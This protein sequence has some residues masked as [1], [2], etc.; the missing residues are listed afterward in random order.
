MFHL[1]VR[2]TLGY[3]VP[4]VLTEHLQECPYRHNAS[5]RIIYA[6]VKWFYGI[7]EYNVFLFCF[8]LQV[9]FQ[10]AQEVFA[11]YFTP[12]K[13]TEVVGRDLAVDEGGAVC[14]EVL[15]KGQ[16]CRF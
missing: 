14:K 16:E 15:R 5:V 8:L 13:G 4:A 6:Y 1:N 12:A 3:F 2:T 10:Q 11:A 9:F 7:P